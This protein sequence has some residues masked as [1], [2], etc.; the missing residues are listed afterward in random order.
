MAR[1]RRSVEAIGS[2]AVATVNRL[3]TTCAKILARRLIAS[4]R[5]GTSPVRSKPSSI[6]RRQRSSHRPVQ[7]VA[8]TKPQASRN[9]EATFDGW[10]GSC[11]CDSDGFLPIRRYW[12]T[13]KSC[14]A[15][16][17]LIAWPGGEFGTGTS[18]KS[19][20]RAFSAIRSWL[21]SRRVRIPSLRSAGSGGHQP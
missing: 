13:A 4:S 9:L 16:V 10:N 14:R 11:P 12:H 20:R 3:F 15:S 7:W 2:L 19:P 17:R 5:S 21:I 18:E 6:A 8:S 1:R